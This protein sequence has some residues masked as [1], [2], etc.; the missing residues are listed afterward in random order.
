[1]KV[2]FIGLGNI[3]APMARRLCDPRFDLIVFDVA[4][5]A[6]QAFEGRGCRIAATLAE[7]ASHANI[8][9]VCVR[10]DAQLQDV[11]E[12]AGG[13]IECATHPAITLAH[14]TVRP[15]TVRQLAPVAASRGL[16]LLDAPVT[17]GAHLAERG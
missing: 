14:S 8:V 12:R 6:A 17:G 11:L 4:R 7:V 3:G 2:G 5:E 1:M 13:L 9:S 16:T 15:S 10:D